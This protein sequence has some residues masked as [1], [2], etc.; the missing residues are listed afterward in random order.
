MNDGNGFDFY[1]NPGYKNN[2]NKR[3]TFILDVRDGTITIDGLSQPV[4]HLGNASEF[5]IDLF[6]PLKIDKH[7]EIYLDNLTTYNCNLSNVSESSAF[8]LHINEFNIK[9]NVASE[10]DTDKHNIFGS[11]VIP[12]ENN[13]VSN[14]F[15]AVIH[16]GKKFNYVCDIN[17]QIIH[18]LSGK[19]S[20]LSGGSAFHGSQKTDSVYTYSISGITAWSG[21]GNVPLTKDEVISYIDI[22]SDS[23]DTTLDHARVL[24]TSTWDSP[25]II[26]TT[27]TDITESDIN[28]GTTITLKQSTRAEYVFTGS[29]LFL[30]KG[31]GRFTAEFTIVAND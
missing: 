16:K 7:S 4:T 29:S 17:P 13:N 20:N 24:V 19:I 21:G 23:T 6:E 22:N 27:T 26:F 1:E 3:Q 2:R 28:G 15:G 18:R 14:Y 25:T 30:R 12:N 31:N 8:C 9:T 5:S 10:D 11:I